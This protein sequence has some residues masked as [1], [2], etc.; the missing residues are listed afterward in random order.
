MYAQHS[1]CKGYPLPFTLKQSRW[2]SEEGGCFQRVCMFRSSLVPRLGVAPPSEV[3]GVCSVPPLPVCLLQAQLGGRVSCPHHLGMD[4]PREGC[5]E[6][7]VRAEWW[8]GGGALPYVPYVLN[9][10]RYILHSQSSGPLSS[11]L[12]LKGSLPPTPVGQWPGSGQ[13]CRVSPW[14]L[15]NSW[16]GPGFMCFWLLLYPDISLP[17]RGT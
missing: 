2:E 14:P 13:H 9:L 1:V 6:Q 3:H 16:A 15:C 7:V 5:R 10:I 4:V 12:A 11:D 17:E 8:G